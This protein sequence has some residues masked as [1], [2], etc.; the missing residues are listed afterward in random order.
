MIRLF[1]FFRRKKAKRPERE[2]SRQ[3]Y[4]NRHFAPREKK[5]KKE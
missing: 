3:E 5:G 1:R 2:I 4:Y